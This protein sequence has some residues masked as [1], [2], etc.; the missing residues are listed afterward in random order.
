MSILVFIF[1]IMLSFILLVTIGIFLLKAPSLGYEVKELLEKQGYTDVKIYGTIK[2]P[3][4]Q[5][6]VKFSA[7]DHEMNLVLGFYRDKEILTDKIN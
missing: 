3:G 2:A 1:G 6:A 4:G 5:L 7:R